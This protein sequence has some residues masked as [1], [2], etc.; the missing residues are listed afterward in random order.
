MHDEDG[1]ADARVLVIV[2]GVGT[3]GVAMFVAI[4][5]AGSM[6]VYGEQWRK[7]R[8]DCCPNGQRRVTVRAGE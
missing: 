3:Y 4:V 7:D 6:L 5:K 2:L 1:M 8:L